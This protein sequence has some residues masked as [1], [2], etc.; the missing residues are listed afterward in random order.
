MSTENHLIGAWE[1]IS[2]E[3][4]QEDGTIKY[5][6]GSNIK[7]QVMYSSDGYM[8]GSFMKENRADFEGDDLVS[9]SVQEFEAAM[10]SYVGYAG[11]YS[12][13]GDRVFHQAT[14]SLFPNWTDTSIERFFDVTGNKLT[15]TTTPLV[16]GGISAV[17]ALVWQKLP[18]LNV[19]KQV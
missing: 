2:F 6:W 7:G 14:V 19:H 12:L 8:A 3:L 1:L 10:K 17:G 9:G 4:R 11:P 15:L 16:F 13:H 18:S 5:P